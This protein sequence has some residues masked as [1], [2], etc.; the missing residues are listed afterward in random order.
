MQCKATEVM[1]LPLG[2]VWGLAAC[3]LNAR[4]Q[5]ADTLRNFASAAKPLLGEAK[6]L[7]LLVLLAAMAF[8]GRSRPP[9]QARMDSTT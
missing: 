2:L 7:A 9:A 5:L 1:D 3:E 6:L 4:V 8:L